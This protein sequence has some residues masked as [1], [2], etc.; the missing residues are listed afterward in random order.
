MKRET[1]IGWMRRFSLACFGDGQ[2]RGRSYA[3]RSRDLSQWKRRHAPSNPSLV[4]K[5]RRV[6]TSRSALHCAERTSSDTVD[7]RRGLE[8]LFTERKQFLWNG[9]Q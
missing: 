7:Y 2:A 6:R 1:Y 9:L 4:R 5:L 8:R 3:L